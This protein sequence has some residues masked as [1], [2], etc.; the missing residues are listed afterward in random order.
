MD[1][2]LIPYLSQLASQSPVLLVYLV[3]IILALVFWRRWPGP[4]AFTLASMGLLVLMALVQPF[5]F[6]YLSRAPLELGWPHGRVGWLMSATALTGSL[7]RATAFG[8]LLAAVFIGRK[9]ERQMGP[10]RP[11]P[12]SAPAPEPSEEYG[13]TRLPGG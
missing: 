2:L 8:L 12:P 7:I 6:L 9:G 11:L 5:V 3:A 1:D 13:I 10:S 4:C